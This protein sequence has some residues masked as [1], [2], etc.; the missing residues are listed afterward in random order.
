MTRSA[1]SSRLRGDRGSATAETAI[2]LPVVV[3]M[4]VVVLLCGAGLAG[5]LRLESAAR[6]AARE[7]ARG[8]DSAT[9]VAVAQRIGGDGTAV[10]ISGSGPWVRVEASR[11]LQAPA[12]VLSGA[13]WRLSADAVARQEPHLLEGGA[14]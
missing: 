14:P 6:G 9:A 11:T 8:E 10:E 3:A 1:R 4:V 12:G 2:V 7:L 5:Q 13:S